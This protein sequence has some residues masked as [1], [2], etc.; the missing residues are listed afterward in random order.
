[1][2]CSNWLSNELEGVHFLLVIDKWGIF[3]VSIDPVD[4]GTEFS[5]CW[6]SFVLLDVL[7][8]GSMRINVALKLIAVSLKSVSKSFLFKDV[9]IPL[10]KLILKVLE[11]NSGIWWE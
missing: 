5:D 7:F 6:L 4:S 1:M 8:P 2:S 9:N 11:H 3:T 10:S